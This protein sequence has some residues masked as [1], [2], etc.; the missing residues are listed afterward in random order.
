MRLRGL[1]LLVITVT[2]SD[3]NT[4]TYIYYY[5]TIPPIIPPKLGVDLTYRACSI[6]C[7]GATGKEIF[8]NESM[9][10]ILTLTVWNTIERRRKSVIDHTSTLYIHICM[11]LTNTAK[12]P[13]STLSR[14]EATQERLNSVS[15][16]GVNVRGYWLY[17]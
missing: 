13:P 9:N 12:V 1:V 8:T 5:M 4:T 14:P 2:N 11:I 17:I 7:F 6:Q 16:R 3:L 15:A 10:Y